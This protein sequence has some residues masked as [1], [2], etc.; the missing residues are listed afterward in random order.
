MQGYL[1]QVRH[2]QSKFKSFN[3]SQVP[4]SRNTHSDSLATLATSSAQSLPQ[5]ILVEDLCRP[6]EAVKTVAY[7]HQIG[8]APSWM[9]PIVLFLK[10]DVLL[11]DKSKADKCI[12]PE[13]VEIILEELH[14]GICGSHTGGRSLSHRAIT[15]GYRWSRMQKKVEDYWGLDIVGHFPKAAGNKRYL[16]VG[17]D[18]FTKWVET[19]PLANIRDVDAKRFIWKNIVTRFGVSRTL[20]LDNGLQFDS[21]AFRKYCCNLGII[22]RYSTPVYPQGNGQ[23]EAVNEVIVSGLKK[24]LDDAKGKW[25]KELSHVLWTYWTTPQRSTRETPFS[26]TYGAEAVIPLENGYPTLRTSSFTL[27]SNDES[28]E[29]SLDL[30]QRT[31]R[32]CHGLVGILPIQTEAKVRFQRK[33]KAANSGRFGFKKGRRS[34][35]E[36]SMGEVRT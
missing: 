11:E 20:I 26:M 27:T 32:K 28:L 16:L 19:E 34:C 18:Y 31:K 25:V 2:L 15:Q 21:K 17:T 14:E 9:D 10:E 6:I 36:P 4:R 35:Q 13:G 24:R 7:V 3:L 12:H 23:A 29:K 33:V 30:N 5:V 8:V 22:N 1:N